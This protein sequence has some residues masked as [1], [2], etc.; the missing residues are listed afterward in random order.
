MS[1]MGGVEGGRGDV[2]RG[3]P[4]GVGDAPSLGSIPPTD[5]ALLGLPCTGNGENG[6]GATGGVKT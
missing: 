6:L 5:G 1:G 3:G 2:A 4:I